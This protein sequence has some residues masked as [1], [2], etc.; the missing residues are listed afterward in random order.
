M[1]ENLRQFDYLNWKKQFL[2]VSLHLLLRITMLIT[3]LSVV[4]FS[5]T[6]AIDV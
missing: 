1:S 3:I 4:P 5:Y 2:F 6:P